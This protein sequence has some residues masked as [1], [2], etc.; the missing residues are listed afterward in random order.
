[1]SSTVYH[2][3]TQAVQLNRVQR[4]NAVLLLL[5]KSRANLK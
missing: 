4:D 3:I 2:A 1:M 5:L